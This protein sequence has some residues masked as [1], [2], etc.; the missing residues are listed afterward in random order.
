L[1]ESEW[2]RIAPSGGGRLV[3]LIA[4]SVEGARPGPYELVLR[5]RDLLA[6]RATEARAG[7]TITM[8]PGE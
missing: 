4:L 6:A 1:R 8:A 3:R 7:F 2:S 5:A